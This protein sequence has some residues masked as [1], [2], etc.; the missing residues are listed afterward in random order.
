MLIHNADKHPVLKDTDLWESYVLNW[1][2]K[3]DDLFIEL[4][5][6]LLPE[7]ASYTPPSSDSWACF[8][9]ANLRF[10]GIEY[11]KGFDSLCTSKPAID[12]TGEKDFGHFEEFKFSK[13][14]EY[15]FEIELAG[16]LELKAE[17]LVLDIA[18]I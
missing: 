11:L 13:L 16:K 14:G 10:V 6:V 4:D 2:L 1:H 12:T 3:D 15:F 7:H 5:I 18:D 9:E 17:S 8:R